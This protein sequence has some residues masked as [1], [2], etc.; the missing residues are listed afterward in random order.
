MRSVSLRAMLLI[1]FVIAMPVLALPAV[2][3]R[4]DDWLYGPPPATSA[5]TPLRSELAQS[6][7]PQ[8]EERAS[9]ASFDEIEPATTSRPPYEGLDSAVAPPPLLSGAPAFPPLVTS[10]P[11]TAA[12]P[13]TIKAGEETGPLSDAAA[14][15]I[16]QIRA[17]LER[18]GA[19]YMILET[20][21]GTGT[22][23]FACDIRVDE[24]T[25][26]SR[27]FEAVAADPLAAAEQ[28]LAEVSRWRADARTGASP[29]PPS[30][31][32]GTRRE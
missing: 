11:D 28:V 9:P 19:E 18:L 13:I 20:T 5:M 26:Y 21:Q 8:R 12:P 24:R 3:R 10:T 30:P 6:L 23:R 25:R 32:P 7:E 16:H 22:Y 17:E 27:P 14:A 4:L 15:R 31:N 29:S 2:A 1:G